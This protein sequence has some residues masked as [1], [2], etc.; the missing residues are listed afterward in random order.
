MTVTGFYQG[1]GATFG[2][3][4][5]IELLD[6]TKTE[7]YLKI[8]KEAEY[9]I[10][11]EV[12][13]LN[14]KKKRLLEKLGESKKDGSL[15][16]EGFE[17]AL[18]IVDQQIEES[19]NSVLYNEFFGELRDLIEEKIQLEGLNLVQYP[20]DLHNHCVEEFAVGILEEYS[21]GEEKSFPIFSDT[22]PKILK[23]KLFKNHKELAFL[24]I[25]NDCNCCS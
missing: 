5:L 8:I 1:F 22:R 23:N 25:P 11:Q 15:D 2:F 18:K 16:I 17:M 10:N 24:C 3:W 9:M 14:K 13:S 20:H 19:K 21:F 12:N 7:E 4:E 6:L